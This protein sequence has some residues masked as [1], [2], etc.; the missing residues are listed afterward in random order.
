MRSRIV[1][2]DKIRMTNDETNPNDEAQMGALLADLL[3]VIR[4][5][6]FLRH[7]SFVLRHFYRRLLNFFCVLGKFV[8]K[9]ADKINIVQNNHVGVVLF[10]IVVLPALVPPAEPDD[11]WPAIRK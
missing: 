6:S 5:L 1:S 10:V 4:P 2:N 11:R 9:D 8:A 3:F 7:S